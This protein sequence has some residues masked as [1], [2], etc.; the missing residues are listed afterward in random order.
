M[1][2]K[3]GVATG[4][5]RRGDTFGDAWPEGIG[6][7]TLASA[8][9]PFMPSRRKVLALGRYFVGPDSGE[10]AETVAT[11]LVRRR[12]LVRCRYISVLEWHV[13]AQRPGWAAMLVSA[14]ILRAGFERVDAFGAQY[15]VVLANFGI[16]FEMA[17]DSLGVTSRW[18]GLFTH[19]QMC[20]AP[21][22]SRSV[23]RRRCRWRCRSVSSRKQGR[24]L[25]LRWMMCWEIPGRSSRNRLAIAGA[26][27]RP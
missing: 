18:G 27:N 16:R 6:R 2:G 1:D 21:R 14:P 26:C 10:V 3:P 12:Q 4:T 15:I 7:K 22:V 5:V 25:S 23:S 11:A 19:A 8:I 24:L 20:G 17:S 13:G 9:E